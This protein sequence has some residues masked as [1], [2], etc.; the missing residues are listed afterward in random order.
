MALDPSIISEAVRR[1]VQLKATVVQR[2]EREAGVRAILNFGHSI[3][4][5]SGTISYPEIILDICSSIHIVSVLWQIGYSHK[6]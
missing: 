5:P 4:K 1:A 3:G 2:D 6:S